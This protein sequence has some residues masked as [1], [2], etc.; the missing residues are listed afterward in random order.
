MSYFIL[1]L[2]RPDFIDNIP[3]DFRV[4]NID[5]ALKLPEIVD[6]GGVRYERV[7]HPLYKNMEQL[8]IV[9]VNGRAVAQMMSLQEAALNT[10]AR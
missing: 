9:D 1:R 8:W 3:I 7:P 10:L 6:R 5:A 2:C 4:L